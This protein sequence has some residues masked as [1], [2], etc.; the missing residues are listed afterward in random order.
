MQLN[1]E[2]DL[3][4]IHGGFTSR[5]GRQ[6]WGSSNRRTIRDPHQRY[7]RA[8]FLILVCA[9]II[10][11]LSKRCKGDTPEG[12]RIQAGASG[13]KVR[14][15]AGSA[16]VLGINNA[17]TYGTVLSSGPTDATISGSSDPTVYHWYNIAWDPPA[18][19][20]WSADV[21]FTQP[22]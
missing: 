14:S 2:V 6:A 11:P 4:T 12:A 1:S 9:I 10:S 8:L 16:N 21:G 17:Y 18:V 5:A 22:T 3:P 7:Y 13:I 15:G 20:G 19:S